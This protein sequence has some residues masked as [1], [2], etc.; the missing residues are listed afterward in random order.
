MDVFSSLTWTIVHNPH[1]GPFSQ[2]DVFSR[3]P[4]LLNAAPYNG[5]ILQAARVDHVQDIM[6]GFYDEVYSPL[7]LAGWLAAAAR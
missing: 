6:L 4:Y 7:R 2:R 1:N 5:E 3:G